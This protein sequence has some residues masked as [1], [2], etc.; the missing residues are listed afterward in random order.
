MT[1]LVFPGLITVTFDI[2]LDTRSQCW[3]LIEETFHINNYFIKFWEFHWFFRKFEMQ[4]L[5]DRQSESKRSEVTAV[6]WDRTSPLSH[7]SYSIQRMC[8]P[9][10]IAFIRPANNRMDIIFLASER[11]SC[12]LRWR[13]SNKKY[14]TARDWLMLFLYALRKRFSFCEQLYNR[15]CIRIGLPKCRDRERERER[16]RICK[17]K[18]WRMIIRSRMNPLWCHEFEYHKRCRRHESMR[19]YCVKLNT[20]IFHTVQSTLSVKNRR[21]REIDNDLRDL[22]VR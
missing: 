9:P 12:Y 18:N 6:W 21:I 1:P 20:H 15:G 14:A 17:G 22:W 16:E 7:F 10:L 2:L 3:V 13:H 4:C 8:V 11:N 5:T 19:T